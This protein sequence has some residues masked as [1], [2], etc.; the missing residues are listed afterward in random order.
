VF[1][2]HLL[3]TEH[4]A[5]PE[6][7]VKKIEANKGC[8]LSQTAHVPTKRIDGRRNGLTINL[9][10]DRFNLQGNSQGQRV[11]NIAG[12][13]KVFRARIDASGRIVI[14]ADVRL[15]HKLKEGDAVVMEEDADGL[16]LR[17]VVDVVRGVQDYFCK[18]IPADVSLVD[19]LIAER[20]EE[21]KRE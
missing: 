21:A 9:G 10:C 19:E 17:S 3:H 20:R 16:R 6:L 13:H 18:L 7:P 15:R 1:C 14:P 5:R 11:G 8:Y 4:L 2:L 12:E